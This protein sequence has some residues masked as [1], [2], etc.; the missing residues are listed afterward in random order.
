MQS[1]A[2]Q[3]SAGSLVRGVA[4]K[5][6]KLRQFRRGGGGGDVVEAL[7]S[8]VLIGTGRSERSSGALKASAAP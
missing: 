3:T 1:T 2:F 4:C 6:T 8:L 5:N 7:Q